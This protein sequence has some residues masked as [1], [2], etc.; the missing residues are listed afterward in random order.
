MAEN[1]ICLNMIVKNESRIIERCIKS[2]YHLIDTWC[3]VDTGSTDG[4]QEII[5][6]L[7]KDKP[8]ELIE[9]PWVN[10]GHNRNEALR[11]A[12]KWGEWTLLTD[13]DMVL[14]DNGFDKSQLNPSVCGY[15]IIQ[16]NHGTRYYNFRLLNSSRNWQCIG[17]T[18]EYYSPKE[19]MKVRGKLDTL[20]FNDIS[21]G[22]SKGD[23]FTRDIALLEQGLIDEPMNHRYMFYLAQSYRDIGNWEKA[24]HWYKECEKHDTWDEERQF[25]S[26]MVGWCMCAANYSIDDISQQ[27]LK[28]W[29]QRPWRVEAL[30]QLGAAYKEKG[31]HQQAYSIFKICAETEY[32]K[33]DVLFI[34]A[35]IYEGLS[36][37][38]FAIAS[39]WAGHYQESIKACEILLSSDYG[40]H[41]ETR[42]RKNLWFAEK[43][44]GVYSNEN[45][46]DLL[47]KIKETVIPV[48]NAKE[49]NTADFGIN[50]ER[51]NF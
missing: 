22:G 51:F 8:G 47:S 15:D 40:K 39:Y 28:A 21:D 9:K 2:V 23:K 27:L 5:K 32:P 4:T 44:F 10:F 1:R 45:L 42:I 33:N 16:E 19:G 30:F 36:L 29:I 11:L 50:D 37:D 7:L 31:M 20:Y 24:I 46:K 43:G 17:V 48:L 3:I 6:E 34:A 14:V 13:A 25:A 41:H 18:H 49:E 35:S 38:E 26:Y 12:E